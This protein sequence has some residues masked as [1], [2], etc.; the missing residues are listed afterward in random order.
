MKIKICGLTTPADCE[1]VNEFP[2]QFAGMVLFYERSR[3]NLE[4]DAARMLLSMLR[5]D[6]QTVAVTVSPTLEQ[7]HQ[8]EEM[9]FDILQVHGDLRPEVLRESRLPIWRAVN[10]G[11]R[12]SDCES[13]KIDAVLMDGRTPGGGQRF[14]WTRKMEIPAG[15]KFVLAGG[16]RADNV[17][18]GIRRFRPDIIDVSSGVEGTSGKDRRK[19]EEFI[20]QAAGVYYE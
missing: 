9:N 6:L 11:M 17:A 19:L 20:R 10:E 12:V 15:K 18:E 3:R 2:V 1:M 4:P 14:D 8:I 5:P 16:L 7:L 13:I